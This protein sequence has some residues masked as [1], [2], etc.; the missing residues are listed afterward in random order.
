MKRFASPFTGTKHDRVSVDPMMLS[1]VAVVCGRTIR[2]FYERPDLGAQCLAAASQ[3]YDRPL[4][5]T[6]THPCPGSPSSG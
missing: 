5:P 3:F 6:D 4:S 2:D 1:H